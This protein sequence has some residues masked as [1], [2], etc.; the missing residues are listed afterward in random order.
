M[1]NENV[2]SL[3]PMNYDIGP[4]RQTSETGTQVV[5][6]AASKLRMFGKQQEVVGDGIDQALSNINAATSRGNVE[7]NLI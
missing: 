1:K 3:D 4:D 5:I 6:T 2:A 7:P